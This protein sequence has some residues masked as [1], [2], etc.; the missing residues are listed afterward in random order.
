MPTPMPTMAPVEI[1]LC[2]GFA[3]ATGVGLVATAAAA[4]VCAA[5]CTG[6]V[7]G[8]AGNGVGK[9]SGWICVASARSAVSVAES[10]TPSVRSA[11]V[12]ARGTCKLF[13]HD[14]KQATAA[15]RFVVGLAHVAQGLLVSRIFESRVLSV[16]WIQDCCAGVNVGKT[17]GTWPTPNPGTGRPL[18]EI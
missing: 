18:Y 11:P 14:W 5:A 10:M 13:A 8:V 1:P 16:V 6:A 7:A 17:F 4:T 12:L 15:A 2:S 3:A 9:S